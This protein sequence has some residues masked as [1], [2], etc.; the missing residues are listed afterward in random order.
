LVAQLRPAHADDRPSL[1][2]EELPALDVSGALHGI[3]PVVSAV[4]LD[5]DEQV[6]PAHVEAVAHTPVCILYR[7]LRDR[8][9]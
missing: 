8:A 7:D 4:V 5:G 3:G 2:R 1:L 9:R 6:W